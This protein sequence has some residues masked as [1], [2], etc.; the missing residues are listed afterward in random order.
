M[1]P[2]RACV[3]ITLS[4]LKNKQTTKTNKQQQQQHLTIDI[5][6]LLK[7]KDSHL[8]FGFFHLNKLNVS[9]NIPGQLLIQSSIGLFDPNQKLLLGQLEL[10]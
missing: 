6:H 3:T 4:T 1:G 5:R 7:S 8:V 9:L 2:P 10:S